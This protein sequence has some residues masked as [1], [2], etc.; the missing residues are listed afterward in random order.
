MHTSAFVET[1]QKMYNFGGFLA[2][3]SVTVFILEKSSGFAPC[4]LIWEILGAQIC[5]MLLC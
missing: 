2:V 4:L 5:K 1:N 3:R